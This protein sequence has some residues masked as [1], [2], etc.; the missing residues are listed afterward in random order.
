MFAVACLAAGPAAA[1]SP[2]ALRPEPPAVSPTAAPAEEVGPGTPAVGEPGLSPER[3]PGEDEERKERVIKSVPAPVEAAE[4]DRPTIDTA[5]RLLKLKRYQQAAPLFLKLR[6]KYGTP[7]YELNYALCLYEIGQ[8]DQARATYE[9]VLQEDPDNIEALISIA[10]IRARTAMAERDPANRG[11]LLDQAREALKRAAQNGANALRSIKIYP[12]LS[13]PFENDVSLKIALIR[14][15]QQRPFLPPPRDPFVNLLPHKERAPGTTLAGTEPEG[16][17]GLRLTLQQQKELVDKI[18]ARFATLEKLLSE[19]PPSYEKIAQT[20]VE[21]EDLAAQA[22][23]KVKAV[24]VIQRLKDILAK[25]KEK[26]MIARQ[27]L[28]QA[29]YKQGERLLEAMET[30]YQQEQYDK[31]FA[32]WENLQNHCR[33]MRQTDETFAKGAGDLETRGAELNRKATILAETEKIQ[34]QITGIIVGASVA[35]AIINNRILSEND[36]VYDQRGNPIA[37]LRI[38]TIKK[39]RVRFRYKGLEFERPL[40][41]K[42]EA[43]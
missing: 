20:F 29:F 27:L 10:R 6:Q 3:A 15:P 11:K 24:D 35:K 17:P 31:V 39:R 1:Q 34:F 43:A 41:L 21:I 19:K 8:L 14:E 26:S 9:K 13:G 23:E 7:E 37:D 18:E 40:V 12:E 22:E 4:Q 33:R 16:A 36:L 5:Y 32:T 42:K 2:D 28:L 38:A 25:V 30:S